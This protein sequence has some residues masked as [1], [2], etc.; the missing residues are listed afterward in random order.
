[1]LGK[2]T[3]QHMAKG[4]FGPWSECGTLAEVKFNSNF[5]STSKIL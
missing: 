2:E 1:M 3:K 4:R 5:L